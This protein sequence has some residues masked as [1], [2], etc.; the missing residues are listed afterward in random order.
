MYVNVRSST[1]HVQCGRR[2][3]RENLCFIILQV[4]GARTRNSN[5]CSSCQKYVLSAHDD[6][7]N[8]GYFVVENNFN[9]AMMRHLNSRHHQQAAAS[10]SSYGKTIKI[11][12]TR[13]K[14]LHLHLSV[15]TPA[16]RIYLQGAHIGHGDIFRCVFSSRHFHVHMTRARPYGR[17][18]SITFYLFTVMT[19]TGIWVATFHHFSSLLQF[20][21]LLRP[22]W[23]L[24]ISSA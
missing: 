3:V 7:G 2:K 20:F 15:G 16:L 19:S 4:S 14:P 24:T 5:R 8:G 17:S 1:T 13:E 10:S 23:K 18:Q 6:N 21:S 12:H 11:T 9:H 22:F